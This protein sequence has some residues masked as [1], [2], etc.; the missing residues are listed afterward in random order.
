M[1]GKTPRA[2][3]IQILPLHNIHFEQKDPP[4]ADHVEVANLSPSGVGFIR[5]SFKKLPKSGDV[6]KGNLMIGRDVHSV[7]VKVIHA[8]GAIVGGHFENPTPPLD[9]AIQKYFDIE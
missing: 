2:P 8:A 7:G 6:L 4:L 5:E 3:R 1:S 9:Q